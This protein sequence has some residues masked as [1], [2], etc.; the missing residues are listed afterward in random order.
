MR[1]MARLY[2]ERTVQDTYCRDNAIYIRRI[3]LDIYFEDNVSYVFRG[4]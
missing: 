2:V 3:M 4:Y 1:M